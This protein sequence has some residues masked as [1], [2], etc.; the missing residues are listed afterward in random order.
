MVLCFS[1]FTIHDLK[2]TQGWKVVHLFYGLHMQFSWGQ[3]RSH[4]NTLTPVWSL[5]IVSQ[6]HEHLVVLCSVIMLYLF[7]L[8]LKLV[9]LCATD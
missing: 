8:L 3:R 4:E 7:R 9:N 1:L 2:E 5:V 6:I